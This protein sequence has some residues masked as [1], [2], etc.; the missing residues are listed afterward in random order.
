MSC[1]SLL[2]SGIMLFLARIFLL[3]L[4]GK[5]WPNTYGKITQS[6]IT[7]VKR[8]ETGSV[9][10]HYRTVIQYEY[11][12]DDVSYKSQTLSFPDQAW[13]ILNRGLRSRQSAKKLQTKYP[14]NQSIEVYYNPK[15]PKQSILEPTIADKNLIL[16]LIIILV[17]GLFFAAMLIQ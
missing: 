12:V 10:S 9:F 2:W 3:G 5:S 11:I 16:T 13:Q 4:K 8:S 6:Q 14:I 1:V 15:N 17:M 7:K